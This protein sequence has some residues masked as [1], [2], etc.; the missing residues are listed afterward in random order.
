MLRPDAA[1]NPTQDRY[2]FGVLT[3]IQPLHEVR[4][5]RVRMVS[6]CGFVVV[7]FTPHAHSVKCGGC[8]QSDIFCTHAGTKKSSNPLSTAHICDHFSML[9]YLMYRLRKTLKGFTNKAAWL[10]D[11]FT[12]E[13]VDSIVSK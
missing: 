6:L 1:C 12:H 5:N 7:L 4:G 8:I 2:W 11:H 3:W 9:S 13:P 10:S